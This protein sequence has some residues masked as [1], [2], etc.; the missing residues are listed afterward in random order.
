MELRRNPC[1]SVSRH[2]YHLHTAIAC[3]LWGK[4][5]AVAVVLAHS[6][7]LWTYPFGVV[8]LEGHSLAKFD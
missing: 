8:I 2:V 4:L 3:R 1:W 6:S 5:Q 7:W